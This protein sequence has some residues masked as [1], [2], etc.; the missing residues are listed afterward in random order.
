METIHRLLIDAA[1]LLEWPQAETAAFRAE[2]T[3]LTDALTGY[4][5]FTDNYKELKQTM[6]LTQQQIDK[7]T[8]EV[9]DNTAAIAV[10]AKAID[11]LRASL[12]AATGQVA[13]LTEQLAAA[14]VLFDTTEL[15]AALA[16]STAQA[17]SIG[18]SLAGAVLPD[19]PVPAPVTVGSTVS[20]PLDPADPS[21][22]T[23]DHTVTD[24][25][26]G[27]ITTEP[28]VTTEPAQVSA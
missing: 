3:E 16:A 26:G 25:S 2:I 10:A 12:T 1:H 4:Q 17:R 6:I 5:L 24:V 8:A 23:V 20:L 7:L 22:A 15:D 14:G 13:A 19:V 27:T 21:G 9:A 11:P 18:E 28:V